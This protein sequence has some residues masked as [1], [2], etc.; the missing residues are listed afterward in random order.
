VLV[1][2]VH[3]NTSDIQSRLR[4]ASM[5]LSKRETSVALGLTNGLLELKQGLTIEETAE[6]LSLQSEAQTLEGNKEEGLRL[7]QRAIRLQPWEQRHWDA[8]SS[9]L[10]TGDLA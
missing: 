6:A 1:R 9:C 8:A 7:A 5:S 2:A 10:P 3:I 4:L